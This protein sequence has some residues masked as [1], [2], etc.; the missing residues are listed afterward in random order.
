MIIGKTIAFSVI[1]SWVTDKTAMAVVYEIQR[2]ESEQL[3]ALLCSKVLA[4]DIFP[5]LYSTAFPCLR[6]KQLFCLSV[7]GGNNFS[8]TRHDHFVSLL[9][10]FSPVYAVRKRFYRFQRLN[11]RLFEQSNSKYSS[12]CAKFEIK[13]G[14]L[15]AEP[16]MDK[17]N[18][19]LTYLAAN[20]AFH[21]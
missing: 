4:L 8:A 6:S 7:S 14:K 5:L 16:R 12:L 1:R 13:L 17:S 11:V 19:L 9:S 2:N 20:N 15:S 21:V 3:Y 18:D 10:F